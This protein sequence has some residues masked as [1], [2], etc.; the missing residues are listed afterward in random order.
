MK[1]QTL[2]ALPWIQKS[3]GSSKN[4]IFGDLWKFLYPV[5]QDIVN[6]AH[7]LDNFAAPLKEKKNPIFV[8][9]FRGCETSQK[10]VK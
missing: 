10:M 5:T 2:F 3:S 1:E 4:C 9:F 6:L 7:I 8:T